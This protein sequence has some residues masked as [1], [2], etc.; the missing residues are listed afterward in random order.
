MPANGISKRRSLSAH[1][2][3]VASSWLALAFFPLL[4]FLSHSHSSSSSLSNYTSHTLFVIA[5]RE[6]PT[7]SPVR[8]RLPW[9]LL[10]PS[11][12]VHPSS[13]GVHGNSDLRVSSVPSV[14]MPAGPSLLSPLSVPLKSRNSG[15]LGFYESAT[16]TEHNGRP[17][18]PNS[19]PIVY[20]VY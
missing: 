9:N 3:G 10:L 16:S 2:F 4:L 1:G 5:N 18:L 6:P 20:V 19:T 17:P 12:L 11:P 15:H 8:P 7:L 13:G 14:P